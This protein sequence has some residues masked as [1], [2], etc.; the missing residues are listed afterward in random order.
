[1]DRSALLDDTPIYDSF[2]STCQAS[3]KTDSIGGHFS[4]VLR[5]TLCFTEYLCNKPTDLLPNLLFVKV[6]SVDLF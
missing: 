5:R 6:P 1:M 2:S 3:F 4:A